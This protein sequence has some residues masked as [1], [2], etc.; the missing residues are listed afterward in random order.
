MHISVIIS[1][2]N[3]PEKLEKVLWGFSCQTY[4]DFE[5][6]VADDGS[7]PETS[8]L[9]KYFQQNTPLQIIHIWHE[10]KGF[11]KCEILNRSIVAAKGDYLIFTDGDCIPLKNFVESHKRNAEKRCFLRG[12]YIKLPKIASENIKKTDILNGNISDPIWLLKNGVTSRKIF[13][14]I[15]PKPLADMMHKISYLSLRFPGCNSSAWKADILAVNG[16]DE[17]MEWGGLDLEMGIRLF[18]SGVKYRLAIFS[19]FNVHLEHDKP[20]I[21]HEAVAKN[22]KLIKETR[23]LRKTW[24]DFGI[25]KGSKPS[26]INEITF[27]NVVK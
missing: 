18:N 6:V 17:R 15:I 23:M 21:N 27:E 5:I 13:R 7:G 4:K 20:Y 8:N 16:F 26:N 25:I 11:R 22:R 1:T 12:C 2:Y 3:S 14:L 24:T 9:I 10:D 19:A